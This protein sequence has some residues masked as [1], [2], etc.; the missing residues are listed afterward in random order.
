MI[1]TIM[2]FV[3]LYVAAAGGVGK[4]TNQIGQRKCTNKRHDW[5]NCGH[6]YT[7]ILAGVAWPLALPLAAGMK[8][9]DKF[10]TQISREEKEMKA[11][12]E[13]IARAQHQLEMERQQLM[14]DETVTKRMELS[15]RRL[16][17][18]SSSNDNHNDI[19]EA[20]AA[21]AKRQKRKSRWDV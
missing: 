8:S 6:Y 20:L 4:T 1:I 5:E 2:L 3:M 19:D 9:T 17:L 16:E 15:N 21:E 12:K 11:R 10:P 7:G 14:M 18:T 13:E